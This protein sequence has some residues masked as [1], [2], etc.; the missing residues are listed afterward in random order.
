MIFIFGNGMELFF[1]YQ[2]NNILFLNWFC[3]WVYINEPNYFYFSL[4]LFGISV[5]IQYRRKK[6]VK[7]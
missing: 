6:K 2:N 5:T 7:I 4:T 1:G 3:S